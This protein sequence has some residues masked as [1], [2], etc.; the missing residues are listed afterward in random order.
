MLE[1]QIQLD[2]NRLFSSEEF[3]SDTKNRE[4]IHHLTT[5]WSHCLNDD[6]YKQGI[7]EIVAIC[8]KITY[9]GIQ[10]NFLVHKKDVDLFHLNHLCPANLMHVSFDLASNLMKFVYPLYNDDS[11]MSGRMN[12]IQNRLLMKIDQPLN[13]RINSLNLES[14]Y[15]IRWLRLLFCR[16]VKVELIPRL[17]D[18]IIYSL[19]KQGNI[20]C[21][22]Y[23]VIALYQAKRNQLMQQD[24]NNVMRLFSGSLLGDM[25][26]E[27]VESVARSALRLM[28]I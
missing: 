21:L 23:I 9:D 13:E 27:G 8:Y 17:W 20:D 2:I 6:V 16:E 5:L 14:V 24:Y 25:D 11:K 28:G 10:N 3:Y 12:L 15:L 26:R 19:Q 1:K 7:H 22:D 18:F 4:N